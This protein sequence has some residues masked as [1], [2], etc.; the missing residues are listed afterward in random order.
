MLL[1]TKIRLPVS[2][3]DAAALEVM[4][5]QCRGRYN[6]WVLRLRDGGGRG[7]G[8]AAGEATREGRKGQDPELRQGYGHPRP[9]VRPDTG[10]AALLRRVT[11]RAREPG[12]PRA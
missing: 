7:P 8:W 1:C 6:W 5:G 4:P 3:A 10:T 12:G 11:G 2:E 9:E